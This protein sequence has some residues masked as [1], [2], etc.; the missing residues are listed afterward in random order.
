MNDQNTDEDAVYTFTFD[1]NTFNDVDFGDSLTYTAKLYNDTQ[2]PDWLNFDPSSRTFT[3]TPL[4][5]DVGMIQI[6]VTA[7]DQSLASIYDS[8][9]LTVNN[10][11]D[12]PTLENAIIDQST[13]EDAVYSFTFNLNTFNDVDI[14]DSLTYAAIQSNNTSLPLWLSFDANTR[15]FSGTPL[16]DD[17]GIYQIKVTA[18]DTSLTSAT[19]IFV[20]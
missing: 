15:T 18:T 10:T 8:F 3:G 1:L 12:A 14:T 17:V 19:D 16:N 4:N 11:N 9:A 5:A 20:L 6:K 13:D 7:T 2:L